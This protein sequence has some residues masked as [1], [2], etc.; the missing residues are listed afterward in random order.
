MNAKDIKL[1]LAKKHFEDIFV[2]EC[3]N[4]AS[5]VGVRIM[6][7]WAMRKSYANPCMTAYEVNVS[8]GDFLQDVK[9]REYLTSC[10]EFYFICPTGLILPTELPTDTGLYWVSKTG[11]RL[12]C[13]KKAPYRKIDIPIGV[14]SYV[15]ITRCYVGRENKHFTKTFWES[16]LSKRQLDADFGHYVSK[17]ISDRVCEEI[18]NV[19][20]ENR[21]LKR[22]METYDSHKKILKELGFNPD[23]PL[24]EYRFREKINEI[25]NGIPIGLKNDIGSAMRHLKASS[26]YLEKIY[27]KQ[28]KG[29]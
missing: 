10:N 2:D 26:D 6:D 8:R 3:K 12:Y 16:W 18:D 24:F 9:W 13:K 14:L 17:K 25:L 22:K 23:N 20:S 11:T 5:G 15:L 1:L 27:E 21:S 28:E 19:N 29:S 4:G 7:G